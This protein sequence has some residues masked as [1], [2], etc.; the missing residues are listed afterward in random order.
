MYDGM[1]F[2]HCAPLPDITE[3]THYL[4][5]YKYNLEVLVIPVVF[6]A[7]LKLDKRDD[8]GFTIVNFSFS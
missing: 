1:D 7:T 6:T 4:R 3:L 8:F 5:I 2:Y